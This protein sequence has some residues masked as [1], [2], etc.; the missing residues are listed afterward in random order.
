MTP[1]RRR[2]TS[3]KA[4]LQ[5][6]VRRLEAELLILQKQTICLDVSRS[7]QRA[8]IA[9]NAARSVRSAELDFKVVSVTKEVL[10]GRF[11]NAV[12]NYPL[13]YFGFP[14][15]YNYRG[16]SDEVAR[17]LNVHKIPAPRG[18]QWQ[19]RQVR[20]AFKRQALREDKPS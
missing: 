1:A 17:R 6:E 12:F 10:S 13:R 11:G 16:I 18:G 14:D 19:A 5:A 8:T 7:N 3:S 9:A 4:A 20:R 15:F 2:S